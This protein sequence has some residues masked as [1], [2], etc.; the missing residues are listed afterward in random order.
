MSLTYGFYNSVAHDRKYNAIQMSSIFDGI[1]KDGIFMSI[2]DRFEVTADGTDMFVAVGTGRAWFNHTWTLND[3]PLP[4]ELPPSELILNRYDAIVLEVNSEVSVRANEIKVVSGTPSSNPVYP[5]MI[6]TLTV[7][8]YPLA[9]IYVEK[10]A[11][12]IRQADI[13]SMIGKDTAP[14]VTG[15]LET[16]DIESMVA[17]WEDQWKKFFETNEGQWDSWYETYTRE[18]DLTAENWK[19]LWHEWYHMY[20]DSSTEEFSKW[21]EDQKADFLAWYQELKDILSGQVE[22][23]LAEKITELEK[24]VEELEDFKQNLSDYH[25]V[26]EVVQDWEDD[27]I[28]DSNGDPIIGQTV[29][30]TG[31]EV[32]NLIEQFEDISIILDADI[33]AERVIFEGG[34]NV[35]EKL[36]NIDGISD[37]VNSDDTRIAASSYAIKKVYDIVMNLGRIY[38]ISLDATFTSSGGN[39]VVLSN[40]PIGV[41]VVV[42]QL[43]DMTESDFT[44]FQISSSG[45]TM[46]GAGTR[47]RY[48]VRHICALILNVT[49]STNSLNFGAYCTNST[50][51]HFRGAAVRIK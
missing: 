5:T 9:Y 42:S 2:G 50:N 31:G 43:Y 48:F 29:F 20:T 51:C 17:Q 15:L 6:N 18:M 38:P 12:T 19:D 40:L 25:A 35:Q 26:Y 33:K 32:E 4:I 39:R 21:K 49:S 7:H 36:A 3:A 27:D 44:D 16:I 28:L 24:K 23:M 13:T 46:Y 8:Q 47:G 30:I 34:G 37:A 1:I 14:Y 10:N 41:Y 22:T 11:T 45:M